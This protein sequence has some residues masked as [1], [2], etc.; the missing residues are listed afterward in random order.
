MDRRPGDDSESRFAAYVEGLVSVIGHAD[1][2]R[3]LR[4]YCMGLMMP[5]ERKSVE[6]MAAVTAPARVAA[7]HQS[8]LHFVGE[9]RW[10]DEKV[11][12]KVRET[13]LPEIQRH[14]AIEAWIIDDT[15][16][17]K[18][19]RH[20]VGVARQ[21]CGQLGKEDNCQV[22]VSLSLANGHASL[23]VA[24]RL[25][26]PQEWT[27]DHA[28]LRKAGVPEDIAFKTKHEIA[29][30]QLRWACEAGLPRGVTLLD[31][32]YGNNSALRADITALKLMYVAGILSNTTVWAPGKR[33][34]PAKKWSGRGRP[35]K[36]LQ[37]DAKHKPVSV[38]ELALGL[39]NHAWR[40]VKWREGTAERLSSRFARVRVRVARRDFKLAESRPPEWLLIE[41]PAGV[42]EP[43]KYWLS[44]LPEDIAF[45]RLVDLAKLRWRIE[46]DYQELKQEVGL[47]HFEGR[48]WRGFHHHAT[49]CIAAYGF[50]ISE[51][52]TIPP[53]EP[54]SARV[55]PASAISDGY[56]P[57][58]SAV[59]ARTT[60]FKFDRDDAPMLD[61][62]SRQN[63]TAMPMLCRPDA[64]ALRAEKFMTQ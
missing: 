25:Y 5:C 33:P 19:G 56:R 43:T 28:R 34:L 50:L 52:E 45:S 20:S 6:P 58:G 16:F 42:D 57:R 53:S 51:R 1:R 29:L 55:L 61:R 30:E 8:L 10:S 36:L 32:G 18:Q 44:T 11:L 24:Y 41:W 7:Q 63:A 37:R 3:P 54:R 60:C 22:A 17:P 47:G 12:A 31:A 4:D 13:V 48:G 9:G 62:S 38:K 39:P 35:P 40:T 49:L 26:L 14:G 23:P 59:A 2:A 64:T 27:T 46:R 21:Y 15:G